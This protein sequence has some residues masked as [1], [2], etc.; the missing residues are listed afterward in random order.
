MKKA[1]KNV[2]HSTNNGPI[3]ALVSLTFGLV[4]VV[5][6]IVIFGDADRDV[7]QLVTFIGII[8]PQVLGYVF[9]SGRLNTVHDKTDEIRENVNG[10]LDRRLSEQDRTLEEIR[11]AVSEEGAD[12]GQ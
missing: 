6:A 11:T 1:M 4:A 9:I 10:K 7:E 12:N 5:A 8:V 2:S 3:Y